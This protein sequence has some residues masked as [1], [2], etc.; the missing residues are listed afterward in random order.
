MGFRVYSVGFGCWV[1]FGCGVLDGPQ[2]RGAAAAPPGEVVL[3]GEGPLRARGFALVNARPKVASQLHVT[4]T[5]LL[6]VPLQQP[7]GTQL[8]GGLPPSCH[9]KAY[10]RISNATFRAKSG[11]PAKG[12]NWAL[13]HAKPCTC[14]SKV[15]SRL[16]EIRQ[17]SRFETRQTMYTTCTFPVRINFILRWT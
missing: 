5:P 11:L 4:C 10:V 8:A 12:S 13:K 6:P 9:G 14:A 15:D 7:L 1:T 3:G 2:G 16:P 17:T